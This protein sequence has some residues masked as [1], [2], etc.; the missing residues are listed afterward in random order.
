MACVS[1]LANI[2]PNVVDDVVGRHSGLEDFAYS[3]LLEFG[4]VL[5]GNNSPYQNEDVIELFITLPD[6]PIHYYEFEVSPANVLFDAQL[7]NPTGSGERVTGGKRWNAEGI[8]TAVRVEGTLNQRGDT[9]RSWSARISIPF[10]ALGLSR[11][12]TPGTTWR[13][14]LYRFDASA[15]NRFLAWSP[16]LGQRPNFHR[17]ERFGSLQFAD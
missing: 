13:V 5:I 7:L 16:T 14:N 2:P 8:K 3:K 10:T 17:L 12:P 6:D 1:A 9:D 11:A 4:N 15:E